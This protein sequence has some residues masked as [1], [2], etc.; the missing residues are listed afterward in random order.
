[1]ILSAYY[2][3]NRP[4]RDVAYTVVTLFSILCSLCS[5]SALTLSPDQC[6]LL[7]P[8]RY[9]MLSF[10]LHSLLCPLVFTHLHLSPLCFSC[11]ADTLTSL[12]FY[13]SFLSLCFVALPPRL[14]FSPPPPLPPSCGH[15]ST[16]STLLTPSGF[17]LRPASICD[18]SPQPNE[19][20]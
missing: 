1:M 3:P 11:S 17:P 10:T 4:H 5:V 2:Q 8:S 14:T 12:F 7:L 20:S 9:M 19:S 13:S 15:W 6:S 16:L 18:C